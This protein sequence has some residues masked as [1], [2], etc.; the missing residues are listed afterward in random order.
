MNLN[1]NNINYILNSILDMTDG[2]GHIWKVVDDDNLVSEGT[3]N[4]E[5]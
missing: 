5:R 2:V 4:T 1:D 3:L